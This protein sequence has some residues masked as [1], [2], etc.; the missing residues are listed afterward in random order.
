VPRQFTIASLYSQ[1]L[2]LG[3]LASAALGDGVVVETVGS[4]EAGLAVVVSAAVTFSSPG[5]EA[6]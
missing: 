6:S 1:I 5:I 2:T 4:F 3:T